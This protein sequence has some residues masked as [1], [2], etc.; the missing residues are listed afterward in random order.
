MITPLISNTP[1]HAA[2]R[3]T[4]Q[5]PISPFATHIIIGTS[6][7]T[8]SPHICPNF[9]HDQ[10]INGTLYTAIKPRLEMW[11]K[12]VE[13]LKV[14]VDFWKNRTRRAQDKDTRDYCIRQRHLWQMELNY[15]HE[16]LIPFRDGRIKEGFRK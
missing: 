14:N 15:W 13:R 3:S 2:N 8:F 7:R 5:T 10:T 1:C 12:R 4:I 6:R 16:K 11:R 9:E